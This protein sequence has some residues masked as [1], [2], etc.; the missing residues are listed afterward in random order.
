[1]ESRSEVDIARKPAA[2]GAVCRRRLWKSAP[3]LLKA[4]AIFIGGGARRHRS[5]HWFFRRSEGRERETVP[6]FIDYDDMSTPMNL[7]VTEKIEFGP[8]MYRY[9]TQFVEHRFHNCACTVLSAKDRKGIQTLVTFFVLQQLVPL[10]PESWPTS[11]AHACASWT[12]HF[13]CHFCYRSLRFFTYFYP[14]RG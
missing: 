14:G 6:V 11:A 12:I 3:S 9:G 2:K 1:M 5:A 10:L 13:A 8:I 4:Q 7:L